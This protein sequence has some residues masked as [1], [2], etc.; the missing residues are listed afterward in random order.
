MCALCGA[1]LGDVDLELILSQSIIVEHADRFVG[2]FLC[3][4]GH[5]REALRLASALVHGDFHRR[6]GSSGGEQGID[7]ILRC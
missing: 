5:E 3:G 6:D 7:F 4:H 2:V 1:W